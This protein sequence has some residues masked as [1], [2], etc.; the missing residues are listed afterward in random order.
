MT[1][2]RDVRWTFLIAFAV[3]LFQLASG[4]VPFLE[5]DWRT[6][7]LSS[8]YRLITCHLLHWSWNH[9]AWDLLLFV[10]LGGICEKTQRGRYLVYLCMASVIIP[11]VVFAKHT[12]LTSYRGL[13]G[14]DS[15][16]FSLIA[17][18]RII[19]SLRSKDRASFWVFS[20][21][22]VGL[23]TKIASESYYGG[24]LFVSDE[25]FVPVPFS[26]LS[27]AILGLLIGLRDVKSTL[28]NS[29]SNRWIAQF[30]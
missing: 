1:S 4:F 17:T 5:L 30:E 16:L 12:E 22:L 18:D 7:R 23:F 11:L 29:G 26:H 19:G 9:L 6:F 21:C 8:A 24:N 20:I 3:L 10:V 25:S 14:I 27:G 15:G 2:L 13:S 28:A